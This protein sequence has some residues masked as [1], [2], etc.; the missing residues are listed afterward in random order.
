MDRIIIYGLGQRFYKV[1]GMKDFYSSYMKEKYIVNG[2][3]DSDEQKVGKKVILGEMEQEV[4]RISTYADADYDKV[5]ITSNKCFDEIKTQLIND[6][7]DE[8]KLI[9]LDELLNPYFE[10]MVKINNYMRKSGVEIGGPSSIFPA[11]YDVCETCDNV[12]FSSSTVWHGEIRGGAEY[13]YA[14]KYLGKVIIADATDLSAIANDYYEFVISSNNLEHIANPIKALKE[15]VRI[16]KNQGTIL[17]AVPMKDKTFDHNR[18]YTSYAHVMKDYLD[19]IKEDDLSHLPEIIERHDYDMDVECGG[20]ENFIKR[21]EK[22][23]ENRC[24][25]HHVFNEEILSDM[26]R[27]VKLDVMSFGEYLGNYLIV[28]KVNK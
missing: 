17:I 13:N 4:K 9:S 27:F 10:K 1:F 6:G 22:N 3:C 8:G 21:A 15:F 25:H 16:C 26:F 12:D 5:V 24:L 18:E 20:K 19:D 28:G 2:I 7:I 11:I 14:G 23:I